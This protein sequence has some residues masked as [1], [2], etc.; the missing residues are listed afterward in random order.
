MRELIGQI[1]RQDPRPAYERAD[2]TLQ[3]YGMKLYDLD[4]RWE[5]RNGVAQVTEIVES[6]RIERAV[7]RAEPD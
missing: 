6:E 4:V 1:L 5:T 7:D 2:P 3:R